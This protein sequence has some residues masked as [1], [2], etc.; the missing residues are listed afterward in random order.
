MALSAVQILTG[1]AAGADTAVGAD[2]GRAV[3]DLVRARLG[4]SEDGRAALA[5]ISADPVDPSAAQGLEEAIREALDADPDFRSRLAAVLAGPP[6]AAAPGYTVTPP[7]T[8]SYNGS[9]VIGSGSAVRRSQ[10]SLGPLTIT[11]TRTTRASLTGIAAIL[12]ALVSLAVYGGV[13]MVTGDDSSRR[14]SG[15]SARHPRD[16]VSSAPASGTSDGPGPVVLDAEQAKKIL[17][18]P[19]SLPDGWNLASDSPTTERCRSS[20]VGGL[21]RGERHEICKSASQLDLR[22][23]YDPGA[24]VSFEKVHIEVLPY[25]STD[26]AAEGYLGLKMEQADFAGGTQPVELKRPLHGDES[27]AVTLTYTGVT[28]AVDRA[29]GRAVVRCG[30]VVAAVYV[31]NENGGIVD[32]GALSA[33]TQAVAARAEQALDGE[34]PTAAVEL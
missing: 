21:G 9:I 3:D 23:V 17:P 25:T 29:E 32:L 18:G 2:A 26:A 14:S 34:T 11:N 28:D 22:S 15:T 31:M 6:P 4:T 27:A 8:S 10:I 1:T 30:T 5:G 33:V 20:R 16:A 7:H 24:A 12:L 19:P 13:Q